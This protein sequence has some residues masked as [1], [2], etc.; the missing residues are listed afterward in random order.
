MKMFIYNMYISYI[1]ETVYVSKQCMYIKS[2]SKFMSTPKKKLDFK[3]KNLT[4]LDV[5]N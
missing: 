5:Y 3:Y 1:I 2:T 4:F